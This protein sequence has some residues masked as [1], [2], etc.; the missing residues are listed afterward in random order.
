MSWETAV[1]MPNYSRHVL[2]SKILEILE[3]IKND[4]KEKNNFQELSRLQRME[5]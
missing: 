3:D 4:G 5:K 2:A 1:K